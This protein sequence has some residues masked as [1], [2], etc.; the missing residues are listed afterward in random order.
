MSDY[1]EQVLTISF[2]NIAGPVSLPP[3]GTD[4][5]FSNDEIMQVIEVSP[6][7]SRVIEVENR[8]AVQIVD[9]VADRWRITAQTFAP[10]TYRKFFYII[11]QLEQGS[12]ITATLNRSF[13]VNNVNRS[14]VIQPITFLQ[15]V[16]EWQ[17]DSYRRMKAGH[18]MVKRE[19]VTFDIVRAASFIYPTTGGGGGGG[20]L[21]GNL[22]GN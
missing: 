20:G 11:Q 5:A 1:I 16:I 6:A 21:S 13:D 14:L 12:A 8:G 2:T 22:G 4:L 19:P 18:G 10:M 3:F 9:R 15:A 7:K 17:G